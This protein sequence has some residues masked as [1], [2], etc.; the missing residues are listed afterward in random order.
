MKNQIN[1]DYLCG[2]KVEILGDDN[3]TYFVEFKDKKGN[4]YHSDTIKNNMWTRCN[5]EY[6][7]DWCIYI[8]GKLY[9]RLNIEGK[10]VFIDFHSSSLGDSLAWIPYVEEFRKKHN[11]EVYCQT[12]KTFLYEKSYPEIKFNVKDMGVPYASYKMGW[13]YDDRLNKNDV[14]TIPLQQTATDILGLDYKEIVANID[15]TSDEKKVIGKYVTLSTQSTA[16]CKYW[17]KKGGWDNIVKYLKKQGYRVICV[18]QHKTFG[19]EKFMNTIPSK[20]ENYTGKP[21]DEVMNLIYH[22]EFHIGI[23]SGLSWL[24]WAMK[25]PT[26]MVSSFSKPFCEFTTNCYR[27]YKDSVKSGYFNDDRYR[28]KQDEWSWNPIVKCESLDD[29]DRFEPITTD[30]VL[31]K[32]KELLDK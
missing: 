16:Q 29:W 18:D 4:L 11:C 17:N 25:K 19:T 1:I 8:D 23:S 9:D 2:P 10:K 26:V 6:Y 7:V 28:F 21:L 31:E 13:F 15:Y 5:T 32:V 24:S 12:H 20:S 14:R 30:D 22:A 3:K 27:V